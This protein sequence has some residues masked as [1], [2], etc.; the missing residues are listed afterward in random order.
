MQKKRDCLR[1]DLELAEAQIESLLADKKNSKQSAD[2]A[3]IKNYMAGVASKS[4]VLQFNKAEDLQVAK[5]AAKAA[6]EA[7]HFESLN[8]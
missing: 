5:T 6:A 2:S 3:A 4:K 8:Y 1:M 7:S